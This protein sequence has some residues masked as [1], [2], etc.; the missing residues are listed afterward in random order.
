MTPPYPSRAAV[1]FW[2][3]VIAYCT[4]GYVIYHIVTGAG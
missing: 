3:I 4:V 1:Y 2:A